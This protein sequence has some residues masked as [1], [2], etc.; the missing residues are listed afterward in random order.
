MTKSY[1]LWLSAISERESVSRYF[2]VRP[3][4]S[5]ATLPK[6]TNAQAALLKT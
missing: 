4:Q 6:M 3:V 5:A 2:P 1:Q